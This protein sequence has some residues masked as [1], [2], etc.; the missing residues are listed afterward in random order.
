M[1]QIAMLRF[2]FIFLFV[3]VYKNKKVVGILEDKFFSLLR[4]FQVF[5]DEILAP[6]EK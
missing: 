4:P 3:W 5:N 1:T 2:L 6:R